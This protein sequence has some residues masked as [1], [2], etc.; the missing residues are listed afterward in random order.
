MTKKKAVFILVFFI[1]MHLLVPILIHF[2]TKSHEK[3]QN[4][5]KSISFHGKI[6]RIDLHTRDQFAII[7]DDLESHGYREYW[8]LSKKLI[9]ECNLVVGDS[10]TKE[11]QADQVCIFDN[12]LK[13]KCRLPVDAIVSLK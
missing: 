5:L 8:F 4:S 2:N 3:L 12:L 9:T 6:K 1:G 7:V 13:E 11:M 10:V